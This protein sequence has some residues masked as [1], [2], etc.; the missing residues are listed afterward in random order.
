MAKMTKWLAVLFVL[1]LLCAML[2]GCGSGTTNSQQNNTNNSTNDNT[3][4]DTNTNQTVE[5]TKVYEFIWAH[6][7]PENSEYGKLRQ[8][9]ADSIYEA[10]NGRVKITLYGSAALG[11]PPDG[12]TMLDTG[13]CDIVTGSISFFAGA[14]PATEVLYIPML[15]YNDNVEGN[16]L[17][18]NLYE[19]SETV[20]NEFSEYK[21]LGLCMTPMSALG[22]KTDPINSIEDF[23]GKQIR[24]SSGPSSDWLMKLGVSPATVGA[25]EIYTSLEKGVLD[26]YAFEWLGLNTYNLQDL[27]A[28]YLNV[29]MSAVPSFTLMNLDKWNALPDD[30]KAAIDGVIGREHP[31]EDPQ[32]IYDLVEDVKADAISG[33]SQMIE[34]SE[35]FM[36]AMQS[37]ADEVAAEWVASN[38]GKFDSQALYDLCKELA[39]VYVK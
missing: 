29:P 16:E 22:T 18:W 8:A 25:A 4:T 15:G 17:F 30:L 34:P 27:T 36:A 31:V 12:L 38:A 9:F 3:N 2:V 6:H 7:D 39:S 35:E 21:V 5:D 24:V 19:Q 11:A 14:F 32:V 33:G 37:A 20:R 1:A 10:T 13:V 28:Y 26:G 23:K